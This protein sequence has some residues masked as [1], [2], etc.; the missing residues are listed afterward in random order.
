MC[1]NKST[2]AVIVVEDKNKR[3]EYSQNGQCLIC[4]ADMQFKTKEPTRKEQQN[5]YKEPLFGLNFR[6]K[7]C[8]CI[9]IL[10][11]YK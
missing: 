1:I 8:Y 5:S 9:T 2:N 4:F 11:R 7:K 3:D 10:Q 6:N